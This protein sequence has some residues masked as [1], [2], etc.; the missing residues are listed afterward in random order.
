M[1]I[2]GN[3]SIGVLRFSI[4]DYIIFAVLLVLS[5]FIGFYYGFLAKRKQDNAEE[6][7]LGGKQ[8]TLFPIAV[9]LIVS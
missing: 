2:D 7:L 1:E 5:S 4:V 3:T 8:M 9:S 6:Y